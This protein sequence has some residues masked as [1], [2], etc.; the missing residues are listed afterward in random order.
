MSTT[1]ELF[2]KDLNDLHLIYDYDVLVDG[3]HEKWKYEM[4]FF[5]FNRI[6][7]KIHGGPMAGRS[8]FQT[9]TYQ[10]IRPGEIWQCNWLEETGTI[11]SLVLDIPNKKIS[12]MLGFSKGHWENAKEAHGD[13]R[14]PEDL[15]R[16]RK[17]ARIGIQT[18][19]HMLSE[20]ADIHTVAKGKMD[21]E[22]I[23]EAWPTM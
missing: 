21:L 5:S 19:R 20:Q 6:V 12:T 1:E 11:V 18:D 4:W 8:N 23:E 2:N 16:W 22:P 13:K 9:A 15:E 17:L 10:C 3:V 14:N 7:Y